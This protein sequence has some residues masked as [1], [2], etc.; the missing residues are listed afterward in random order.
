MDLTGGDSW[1]NMRDYLVSAVTVEYGGEALPLAQLRNLAHSGEE[2]VR[3]EAYEAELSAYEPI[4][5]PVAFALSGIKQQ[6]NT[7]AALRKYE[8]PLDMTLERL[9]MKRETLNAMLSAIEEALPSFW[10]YLKR[11]GKIFGREKGLAWWDLFA[12]VGKSERT[13]TVYEAKEYLVKHFSSFAPDMADMIETAFEENWIDLFPRKG[14][15]GGASCCSVHPKKQFRIQTN[16]SGT[17]SD[18]VT[19]AHELGH[20][21]H[22]RMIDRNLPLNIKCPAPLA[23][24]ASTFN[25]TVIMEA[26]IK[27]ASGEEK[28]FLLE[29]RLQDI[30]QIMCDIYSRFLFESAVFKRRTEEFLF[31]GTLCDMML[32]AQKT[33]YGDGLDPDTLHPYM[34]ICKGHYY[35]SGLSFYNFPYA[36]GGLFAIGLY[37]R[38]MEEGSS[39]VE[40]YRRLLTATTTHSIEEVAAME[41]VDITKPDFWRESLAFVKCQIEEFLE[42]TKEYE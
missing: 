11:K 13:F 21:F 20:G 3:R 22:S 10:R 15:A 6:V 2:Q 34:W 40:K 41:G 35:S 9:H 37:S 39:F 38:Y 29:S 30:T 27:E 18:V 7:E 28:L 36:F 17:L 32:E 4:K 42:L 12:P 8:S 1:A 19:L 5:E 23:E 25:E 24:T 31:S 16:F 26:A 33:A 14:K